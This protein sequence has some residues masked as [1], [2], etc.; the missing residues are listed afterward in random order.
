VAFLAKACDFEYL[1]IEPNPTDSGDWVF[2][3]GDYVPLMDLGA[4]AV[5]NTAESGLAGPSPRHQRNPGIPHGQRR[6]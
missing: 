5:G 3:T 2:F 6:P 1:K 4:L